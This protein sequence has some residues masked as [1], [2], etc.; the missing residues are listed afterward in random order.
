MVDVYH[1]L[2]RPEET[3]AQVRRALKPNGRLV[4]IEYRGEDPAVPIKPEHKMTLRQV[5]E[6]IEPLGFKFSMSSTF[7]PANILSSLS[8][9]VVQTR[10]KLVLNFPV[11]YRVAGKESLTFSD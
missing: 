8:H 1:E 10:N 9:V 4:L 6:E 5:R 3:I 11:D 7:F 2:A